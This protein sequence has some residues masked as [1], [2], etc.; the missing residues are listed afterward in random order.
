[1]VRG[2]PVWPEKQDQLETFP[3]VSHK[4]ARTFLAD[5][6]ELGWVMRRRIAA[7]AASRRSRVSP[8]NGK[9]APWSPDGPA[10]VLS[11]AACCG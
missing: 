1:M 8:V 7:G 3:G 9:V 6:P 2:S 11:T 4:V 5:I 10:R